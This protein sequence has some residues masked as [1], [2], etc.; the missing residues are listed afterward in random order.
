MSRPRLN[1]DVR[2]ANSASLVT[3][4]EESSHTDSA[5]MMTSDEKS[6]PLLWCRNSRLHLHNDVKTA[7]SAS[8]MGC[9]L[10]RKKIYKATNWPTKSFTHLTLFLLEEYSHLMWLLYT[11]GGAEWR[12]RWS[13][14]NASKVQKQSLNGPCYET[15][16]FLFVI[17]NQKSIRHY[18]MSNFM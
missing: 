10:E 4:E 3:S 2:W 17:S 11:E 13:V 12:C 1:D 7:N 6:T 9:L 18:S 15:A 5:S 8:G 14:A 16:E